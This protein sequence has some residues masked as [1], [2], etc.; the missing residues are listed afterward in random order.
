M[1]VAQVVAPEYLERA[2]QM[3]ARKIEDQTPT[4]YEFGMIT[5]NG[6]RRWLE[7]SSRLTYEDGVPAGAQCIGRDI[8]E[9]K[10]ADAE[11]QAI[12]EIV[13]SV[14]TTSNL[15]ELFKLAHRS[16]SKLLPAENCFVALHNPT[17]NL[18]HFEYWADQVDSI[19][20][21]GPVGKGFTSYVLRTGQPILLTEE[22]INQLYKRGEVEKRGTDSASWL[23]VPLRTPS[24][25]IGVLV[26]QHY[27]RDNA[28][29]QRDLELLASVGD[30]LALAIERKQTEIELQTR[31]AQ[32]TE[33]QQIAHLGNWEWDIKSNKVSWSDEEFRIFGLE[34]R[35]FTPTYETY[36]ERIHPDERELVVATIQKALQEKKYPS[37]EHRIVRP[38]GAVRMICEDGKVVLDEYGNPIK[39][40]G[41]TMDITERKLAE[42]NLRNSEAEMRALFASMTDVILVLDKEGRYLKIPATNPTLL[43]KPPTELIGK[44]IHEVLPVEKAD[45][46]LKCIKQSLEINQPVHLDYNLKIGDKEF[47]FAGTVSPMTDETVLWV[48]RDV[49]ERKQMM[50][51]LEQAR[52]VALESVR[53][54]SE[55]LANMSHEI[56]TPMNGVI[57]MTELLLDTEL[58]N[59]QR[60]FA[61]I[62]RASADSLLTI[63]N[64]ILDFSKIEAGKLRFEKQNFDLRN[65]VEAIVELL[66]APAQSKGLELALLVDSDVPTLVRGDAGRIR[67][68]LINLASNAV[69][70]T[71]RGEVAIC[72]SKEI[73]TETHA[74][75]RF[76]VRDTGIG[77]SDDQQKNLFQAFVQAD[78]STTRKYGGTGLG[79]A[80]SKQIVDMMGGEIG[81]ESEQ[82]KG[83]T[84]HFTMQLEKQSI[85]A[86]ALA[87]QSHAALHNL[88]V[89][90]VDDSAINC[91]ILVH[92]TTS[93]GMIPREAE[94]GRVAIEM[95]R[96]AAQSHEPFDVALLD[97]NMPGIDGF[98][99]ARAIKSDAQISAVR[100]VL[101]PSFGNRGD[102][103]TAREIGISA[104]LMKP[105]RQSQLSD[106]LVT[107]MGKS[108]DAVSTA[109]LQSNPVGQHPLAENNSASRPR[110]LIAEDNPV[111]QEVV[112][113]QVEKLGYRADVACNGAEALRA[114]TKFPY[115]IVLMDCQ[116][117]EMDG[118]AATTE[119][120]RREGKDKH[121][122]VIALTA[123][124]MKGE[125]EK[126]LAAG[127]DDYVS[128]PVNVKELQN[129]LKRWHPSA[130]NPYTTVLNQ[131][132]TVK[133]SSLPVDMNRLRR[134]AS[135]DEELTRELTEIYLRQ[136]SENLKKLKKAV[137]T[138]APDEIKRIA[139][140]MLGGSVTC[141]M[142]AVVVPLRELEQSDYGAGRLTDATP[143]VNRV[144][145][146]LER[147]MEFFRDSLTPVNK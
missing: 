100:L 130:E 42:D 139:H 138:D 56:R 136:M 147:I 115:H 49:T 16:I 112:R 36:L 53:L 12:A 2:R 86:A 144:E 9:R 121:T 75:I 66:A 60:E 22:I 70:F 94:N 55:F 34:P 72:V 62:V 33:S 111:N 1:N 20:P 37:F 57:G 40:L 32:L 15:D 117:P 84:F 107:V 90:I 31:E 25:T 133:Q 45:P 134:A 97:F 99:L 83:S 131:N 120:R 125:M 59:E 145:K 82:D 106:C 21:P 146:E 73:E 51:E 102:A 98:E 47:W 61:E 65:V 81:I 109:P 89:L 76:T 35:E 137:E 58:D 14:I 27:E 23:G 26:V 46:F 122:V 50:D 13:Q 24:R 11:R 101:M 127:M 41:I 108:K 93:W 91:K 43:Y 3:L 69:K 132:T 64:D 63:I 88:R 80:I 124:A 54:K 8:T 7:V 140:T 87:T 141:G 19:P 116:M 118:Y 29:S 18:I 68:V 92:Q 67:Q 85:N 129:V 52:D 44:T 103:Q 39:L 104:Y 143:L 79:L 95:L 113:R 128:K 142:V 6:E 123:N 78:G 96:V 28:Y 119:I 105:I 38:D 114:L 126:C 4:T 17:T 5:K 135:D 74:T 71:E 110:V 30:Q 10:R 77:I 48:V